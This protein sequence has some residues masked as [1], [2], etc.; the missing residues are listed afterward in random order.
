MREGTE[1]LLKQGQH[2]WRGQRAVNKWS[3]CI[4]GTGKAVS[5]RGNIVVGARV[6]PPTQIC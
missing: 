4:G 3:N 6:D 5:N 1:R 2:H